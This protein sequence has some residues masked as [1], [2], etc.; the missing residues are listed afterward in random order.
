MLYIGHI[1]SEMLLDYDLEY[2]KSFI[3]FGNNTS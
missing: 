3:V 2:L 1:I